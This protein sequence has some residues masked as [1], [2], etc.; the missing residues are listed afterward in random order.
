MPKNLQLIIQN[1]TMTKNDVGLHQQ[2][3]GYKTTKWHIISDKHIFLLRIQINYSR[4]K[5]S[6]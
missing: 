4:N 6:I 2:N 3:K 1:K 5:F